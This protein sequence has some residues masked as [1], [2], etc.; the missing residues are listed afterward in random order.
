MVREEYFDKFKR[1]YECVMLGL[2]FWC[3]SLVSWGRSLFSIYNFPK[4]KTNHFFWSK[5]KNRIVKKWKGFDLIDQ[6]RAIKAVFMYWTW[7]LVFVFESIRFDSIRSKN[8]LIECRIY[9][10]LY[11]N[12]LSDSL[13]DSV[14]IV[15]FQI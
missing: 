1:K 12:S 14:E 4:R 5:N 13:S 10:N 15:K 7:I 6:F 3:G 9:L 8:V 11:S 2:D